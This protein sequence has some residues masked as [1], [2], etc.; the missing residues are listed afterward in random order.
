MAQGI[1]GKLF[2][3]SGYIS[4]DLFEKLSE[5]PTSVDY[6]IQKEHETKVAQ[7]AQ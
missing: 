1:F 7:T 2:G 3:E 5:A 4:Q 6:S